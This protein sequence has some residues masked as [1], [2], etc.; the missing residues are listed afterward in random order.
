MS[1]RRPRGSDTPE[2]ERR[3]GEIRNGIRWKVVVG[4]LD[5]KSIHLGGLMV[6]AARLCQ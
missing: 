3:T 5:P 2:S 1:E 6:A 4:R